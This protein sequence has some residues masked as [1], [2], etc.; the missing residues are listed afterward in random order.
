[1][2]PHL[3]HLEKTQLLSGKQ[4]HW[5]W[6]DTTSSSIYE[7]SQSRENLRYAKGLLPC[8]LKSTIYIYISIYLLTTYIYIYVYIYLC[9]H[10]YKI[11]KH[12]PFCIFLPPP[13]TC[14]EYHS[15][16]QHAPPQER[17]LED[18][19]CLFQSSADCNMI[20]KPS[21]QEK[22]VNPTYRALCGN[23]RYR[24]FADLYSKW[25]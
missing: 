8:F 23:L 25:T 22:A 4:P 14:E 19:I 6:Q 20:R 11:D 3:S 7:R 2:I 21:P 15:W 10:A 12:C 17:G 1:M 5:H 9:I 18:N 24:H 13:Q 16:N